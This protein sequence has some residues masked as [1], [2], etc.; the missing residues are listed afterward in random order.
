MIKKQLLL[1]PYNGNAIEALDCIDTNEFEFIGFIDDTPE[2]IGVKEHY[3][4]FDRSILLKFPDAMVLAVPGSPT[5]Y[6][7]RDKIIAGLGIENTR[8]ATVISPKARVA[9]KNNIGFNSLIMSGVVITSNAKVGN[10]VCVLP[11]SVIHHDSVI[12]DYTLI[13]SNITI[14]GGTFIGPFCYIGSGSN[15][16]N[17]ITIGE[18]TIVGMGTN[19]IKSLP[20]NSKAVGNPV[21]LL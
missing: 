4:V 11:N 17:G 9:N 14:A 1:F 2:K 8:F 6:T 16:I 12:G 19:V 5:S 18:K 15:I 10:H 20:P 13:G 7:F 3:E 21:R